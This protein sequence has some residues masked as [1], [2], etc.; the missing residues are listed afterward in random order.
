MIPNYSDLTML[1]NLGVEN[2]KDNNVT[3]ACNVFSKALKLIS[4]ENV[5]S[6]PSQM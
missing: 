3:L 2:M 4:T 6:L 1:N 5:L